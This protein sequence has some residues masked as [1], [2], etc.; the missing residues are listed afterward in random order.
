MILNHIQSGKIYSG[1][2]IACGLEVGHSGRANNAVPAG[3]RRRIVDARFA[4]Q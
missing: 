4:M 1:G 2:A 3:G